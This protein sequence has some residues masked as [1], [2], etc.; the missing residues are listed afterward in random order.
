M[1]YIRTCYM[2]YLFGQVWSVIMIASF[3]SL[4]NS[5]SDQFCSLV[6]ICV[7]LVIKNRH[8]VFISVVLDRIFLLI[9]KNVWFLKFSS[10]MMKLLF[11]LHVGIYYTCMFQY[12]FVSI[13]L[14]TVL[15]IKTDRFRKP[16]EKG[17][18]PLSS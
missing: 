13:C 18:L 14:P 1:I 11:K 6:I 2:L 17:R 9:F 4:I 5:H 10:S 3:S 16:M 12:Q 7:I 15:N 8:L